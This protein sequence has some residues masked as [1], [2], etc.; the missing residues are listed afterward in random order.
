MNKIL[1]SLSLIFGCVLN[2]SDLCGF[3]VARTSLSRIVVIKN[4]EDVN[5]HL[6]IQATSATSGTNPNTWVF[7]NISASLNTV[8][9]FGPK[10]YANDTGDFVV[11]WSYIDLISGNHELAAAVLLNS[12]SIWQVTNI[13]QGNGIVDNYNYEAVFDDL[14]NVLVVWSAYDGSQFVSL[15][16]VANLASLSWSTPYVFPS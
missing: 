6:I 14:G 3:T 1:I 5:A 10:L 13:S 16:S 4:T 11:L 2:H 9:S 8:L 12:S 15:I 7:Q